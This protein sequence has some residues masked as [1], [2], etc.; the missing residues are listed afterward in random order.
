MNGFLVLG[1]SLICVL[2]IFLWLAGLSWTLDYVGDNFTF[3]YGK[4]VVITVTAYIGSDNRCAVWDWGASMTRLTATPKVEV[5]A[6]FKITESEMQALNALF[7][8]GVDSLLKTYYEN[9]GTVYMKPHESGL[10][11]LSDVVNKE[12]PSILQKAKDARKVFA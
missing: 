7:T 1:L 12:F 9:L 3:S 5:T 8:Y 10:R 11:S 6:T 2:V 4:S